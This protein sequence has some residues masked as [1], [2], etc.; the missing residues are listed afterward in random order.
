MNLQK[1]NLTEDQIQNFIDHTAGYQPYILN[2]NLQVAG[3]GAWPPST[4]EYKWFYDQKAKSN[5]TQ[6]KHWGVGSHMILDR[7]KV[8]AHTWDLMI[9]HNNSLRS[10]FNDFIKS[11]VDLT[12][13]PELV[14]EIG[15]NDG[16]LLLT[17]LEHGCKKAIGYDLEPNHA[18]VFKLL[19]EATKQDISF[20]NQ[21]YNSLT[22]TMDQCEV[23]DIVIANAVLPHLSDPLY[24]IKHLSTVT[25]KTLLISC[26][27][28]QAPKGE[29]NINFHGTPKVYGHSTFP[30]VFTHHTTISY[31]LFT[32]ALKEC[33]FKEIYE[34]NHNNSYPNANWYYGQHNMGFIATK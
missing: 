15:C 9:A 26:G 19:A 2:D 21:G 27:V 16:G 4:P 8:D 34:I 25:K 3:R 29:M 7:T 14:I 20:V 10:M 11:A 17:A 24:F 32:Y 1:Y 31:D 5:A 13:D 18:G 12:T 33:G 30:D 28:H 22:H 6:I 23:A